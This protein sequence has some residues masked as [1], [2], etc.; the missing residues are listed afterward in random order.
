MYRVFESAQPAL[1][2][3]NPYILIAVCL[4]ATRL[5]TFKKLLMFDEDRMIEES[6]FNN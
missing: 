2:Q 4:V 5:K 6:Q 1:L 3:I